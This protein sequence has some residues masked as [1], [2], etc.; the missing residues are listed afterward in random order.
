MTQS[1]LPA[2]RRAWS[3]LAVA[4]AVATAGATAVAI[5]ASLAPGCARAPRPNALGATGPRAP[6]AAPAGP[7]ARPA[8]DGLFTPGRSW[9]FTVSST[10]GHEDDER[11]WGA[12]TCRVTDVNRFPGGRASTIDCEHDEGD[13]DWVLDRA[14]DELTGSW[15]EAADGRLLTGS[16]WGDDRTPD[17]DDAA[18]RLPARLVPDQGGGLVADPPPAEEEGDV[19][20]QYNVDGQR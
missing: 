19:S 11:T 13:D 16:G 18:V 4:T 2:R 20:T 7:Y 5:V 14:M 12:V 3:R 6:A 9:R 10:T 15:A 1:P 8:F 17:L